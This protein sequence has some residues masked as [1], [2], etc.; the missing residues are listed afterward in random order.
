MRTY[1]RDL[2]IDPDRRA[3]AWTWLRK[4]FKRLSDP[5]PKEGRARFIDLTS[6]LCT[7]SAHAEIDW[8]FKPMVADLLG[9]PRIFANAL[10]AA[11]RCAAWRKARSPELSAALRGP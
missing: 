4:D 9:A 5:V 7:D 11:D 6:K 2:F 3:E 10:E 1:L 8:F